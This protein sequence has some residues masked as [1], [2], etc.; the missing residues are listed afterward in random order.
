MWKKIGMVRIAKFPARN[1]N[2]IITAIT[3][4]ELLE[5]L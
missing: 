1:N 4:M 3:G 2:Y 5:L